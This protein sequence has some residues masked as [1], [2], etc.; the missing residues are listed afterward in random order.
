MPITFENLP[1]DYEELQVPVY[2]LKGHSTASN[3]GLIAVSSSKFPIQYFEVTQGYFKCFLNL[4][5]GINDLLIQHIDGAFVNGYPS[6][7][8]LP[9]PYEQIKVSIKYNPL[10]ASLVPQIHLCVMVGKDSPGLFDCPKDK[11]FEGNG[12]ETA[13][14]KMRVGGRIM[15][16]FTQDEMAKNGLGKRSFRFVEENSVSTLSITDERNAVMRDEIKI[17]VIRSDRTVAEIRDANFAQQNKNAKKAGELFDMALKSL[18]NY[19]G[20]FSDK[21]TDK[22]RAIAAVLILDAHWDPKQNLILGH[23]ALG[24][25]T[26]RIKLAIFGSQGLHSW[27]MNVESI[28]KAF[29]DCTKLNTKEV[30]NDCN[31][32]SQY[33]ECLTVS[34]GAFMHEIGHSLG[35]PHQ[36]N[37]V[38]LRDYVTMNR[39]FLTKERACVRT[40]KGEWGPVGT[41]SEPGWHRLDLVRF[42]YH[43]AFAIPSDLND[44]NFRP[45]ESRVNKGMRLP[46]SINNEA[47]VI[48][49]DSENMEIRCDSGIYLIECYIGEFSRLHYEYLPQFYRGIGAQKVI[50]LNLKVLMSQ[51]PPQYQ[52]TQQPIKLEIL[53]CGFGQKTIDNV[54]KYM[55]D[56]SRAISIPQL[57][58][59]RVRRSDNFGSAPGKDVLAAI[60]PTKQIAVIRVTHGMALDGFQIYFRDNSYVDF[61]NSKSHYSDFHLESDEYLIGINVRSGLWVDAIQFVTNKRESP[62]FGGNGGGLRKFV[63]PQGTRLVGFYGVMGQWCN[64]VGVLYA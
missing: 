56:H 41:N 23:A 48:A 63:V 31:E 44:M 38:M 12:L 61:G 50:K 40:R 10:D 5:K 37:G 21:E 3:S 62:M 51:L 2:I 1:R 55:L 20:P 33:W 39:K 29:T 19:G 52:N 49:I 18:T 64:Q 46:E 11:Q 53:S 36:E 26:D 43:P 32:C 17:H 57:P 27:P 8:N 45:A 47:T 42:L 15:Q 22:T 60:P 25:G 13:I 9:K 30:A 14:R 7:P 6:L 54:V 59:L 58:N 4:G 35:C 28:H 16:A 34:L 24:G